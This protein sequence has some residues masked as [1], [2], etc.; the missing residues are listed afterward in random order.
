MNKLLRLV[1]SLLGVVFLMLVV[2]SVRTMGGNRHS[3]T[4]ATNEARSISY[5]Y[6]FFLPASDN[7]YFAGL[8]AG[9]L[10]AAEVMNCAVIFHSLTP[11]NSLSLEMAS[12]TGVNGVAVFS[13]DKNDDTVRNLEKLLK[14]GVPIVQIENE[15]VSGPTTVYGC[16]TPY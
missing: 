12:Y 3:T 10:E 14:K 4:E 2:M 5:Q 6:A 8:K 15:V 9:A 11:E 13:Y 16:V 1:T 7:P